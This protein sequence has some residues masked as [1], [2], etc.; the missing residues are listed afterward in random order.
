LP[1]LIRIKVL[2]MMKRYRKGVESKQN[3]VEPNAP[4]EAAHDGNPVLS[5]MNMKGIELTSSRRD[6]LK[7]CGYS[8]ALGALSSCK[9]RITRAIPYVT[10]PREMTPGEALWYA[11]SYVNGSDYCSILVK[12]RDGR[13]IKIEGNPLSGVTRGGTNARVQ[14]SVLDLYDMSRFKGPL[15]NGSPV[16]WLQIDEEITA[17]LNKT[18]ADKRSVVLLTPS[19][20]SPSTEAVI[21]GFLKKFPGSEW[22][23][24][25]AISYS[26][27]LE[28]NKSSFG[29]QVIPEYRFDRAE[30]IVSVGADFLGTWL[31]PIVHKTVQFTQGS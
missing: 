22:V 21:S 28:A 7:L 8:F 16:D 14:A 24:Y 11:S 20:F 6:F 17:G 30:I 31:S 5:V 18:I 13:P 4:V 26:A 19:V 2:K 10:A 9:S 27:M 15:K 25:D 3:E 23:K 29:R 12:T 1:L